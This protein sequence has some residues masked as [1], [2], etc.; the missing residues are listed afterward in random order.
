V[1]FAPPLSVQSKQNW[2]D[3]LSTHPTT[4][5]YALA[6]PTDTE[7]TDSELIEQLNHIYSL[8][9]GVNNLWLIPSGGAMGEIGVKYRL[10]YE[11]ET[12]IIPSTPVVLTLS[13]GGVINTCGCRQNIQLIMRETESD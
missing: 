6:T 2:L 5:Y 13:D 3:W 8:Y 7:I 12:D 11:E 4:V 10:N 9:G 1:Y